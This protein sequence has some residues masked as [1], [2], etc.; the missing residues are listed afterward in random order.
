M[1]FQEKR[2]IRRVLSRLARRLER[3]V[4]GQLINK[5]WKEGSSGGGERGR[6]RESGEGG[7][8]RTGTTG[9]HRALVRGTMGWC[10]GK[11]EPRRGV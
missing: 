7:R 1:E 4:G 6:G 9:A 8:E 3:F 11:S 2:F 10:D 5:S